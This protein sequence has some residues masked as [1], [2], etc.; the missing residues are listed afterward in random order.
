M[1]KRR[2]MNRWIIVCLLCLCAGLANAQTKWYDPMQSDVRVVNGQAWYE[3]LAGSYNRLPDRIREKIRPSLWNLSTHSAGLSISFRTNVSAVA[4][5]YSVSGGKDMGHMPA[6]GVSGVDLYVRNDADGQWHFMARDIDWKF[7][8]T[9][10]Y[11]FRSAGGD[12]REYMLYLPLYNHVEWM[13]V[14]VDSAFQFEWVPYDESCP[15]VAY[16]TSILQ[17]GC[18]SRP[19]MAWTNIL[20]RRLQYPILNLGF[21]GNGQMDPEI[22]DLIAEV[23]ARLYIIDCIPNVP[24]MED[25]LFM[26]RFRYGVTKLREASNAPILLVEHE[27]GMSQLGDPGVLHKNEL[28]RKCY[29]EMCREGVKELYLFKCEEMDF[30]EDGTV[31]GVHPNDLGMEATAA[32]YEKKIREIFRDNRYFCPEQKK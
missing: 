19:G 10:C 15:I 29:E 24:Y 8:D 23:P 2:F 17:G 7:G 32:G 12:L 13:E 27:G 11:T 4:V 22:I 25:E 18:A 26:S 20:S 30:P 16:G 14:G 5:R 6:T 3:E 21:S 28:L 1:K 31:D 9:V